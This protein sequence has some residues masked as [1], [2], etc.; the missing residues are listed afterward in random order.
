MFGGEFD[1]TELRRIFDNLA[2]NIEKYAE[3]SKEVYMEILTEERFVVIHQRN[4]M[5][6]LMDYQKRNSVESYGIGLQSIERLAKI[7]QGTMVVSKN[8]NEFEIVIKIGISKED[9]L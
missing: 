1:I 8:D 9:I 6:K 3:R 5:K 2:S 4:T 7:Y